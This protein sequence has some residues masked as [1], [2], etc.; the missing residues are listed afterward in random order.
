MAPMCP[1]SLSLLAELLLPLCLAPPPPDA[2]ALLRRGTELYKAGVYDKA[3]EA[4]QGAWAQAPTATTALNLAQ[5][6]EGAGRPAE[7]LTWYGRVLESESAGP[8][9][10]AAT[11]G[12]DHLLGHGYVAITCGPPGAAIVVGQARGQ[13]PSWGGYLPAGDHALS[14]TAEGREARH[15][16]L[17]VVGGARVERTFDLP[18]RIAVILPAPAPESAPAAVA[19]E[20]P[21]APESEH[22]AV[23]P[24]WVSYTLLGLGGAG[25]IVGGLYT[26]K[27]GDDADKADGLSDGK[28][29]DALEK[30]FERHRTVGYSGLGVGGALLAAGGGLLLFGGGF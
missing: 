26:A 12:R 1:P 6:L 4:F 24:A 17:P 19:S 14:V 7:A 10:E 22:D 8:R 16:T 28:R 30:D 29:R 9:R 20:T 27:A 18:Q 11:S 23:V 25:L 2:A 5:S 3:A 13:C 21:L 15:D